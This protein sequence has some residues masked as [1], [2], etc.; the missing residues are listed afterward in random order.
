MNVYEIPKDVREM[1]RNQLED[2]ICRLRNKLVRNGLAGKHFT[3]F[4]NGK[5]LEGEYEF[6]IEIQER[7]IELYER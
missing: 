3:V 7:W 6:K 5:A 1:A 4:L 2:E